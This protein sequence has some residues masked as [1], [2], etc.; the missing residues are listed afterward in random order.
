MD[1]EAVTRTILE[2]N[3]E[4]LRAKELLGKVENKTGKSRTSIY[5]VWDRLVE[6]NKLFREKGRYYSGKP[7]AK[8]KPSIGV[9]EYLDHRAECKRLEREQEAKEL[10]VNERM[11]LVDVAHWKRIGLVT[12]NDDWISDL[13]LR[14]PHPAFK[15]ELRELLEQ[16]SGLNA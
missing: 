1:I 4:G 9:F 12:S 11:F 6:H 3:P 7:T 5:E 10:T 14:C 16:N 8:E 13:F 15:V 2:K